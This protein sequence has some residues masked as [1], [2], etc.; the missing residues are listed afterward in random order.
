MRAQTIRLI[1][2]S[3]RAYAKRQIDEAPDG[4]IAQVS[5]ETRRIAQNS[6][7][8][9]MLGDVIAQTGRFSDYTIEDAKLTFMHALRQELRFLPALEGQGT[10]PVGAKTSLLTVEQFSGLVEL[11]FEWGARNGVKWSE[12]NDCE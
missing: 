8:H 6:K 12:R 10:F 7:L 9:A 2:A 3:Q 1:G 4:W 5:E 11:I